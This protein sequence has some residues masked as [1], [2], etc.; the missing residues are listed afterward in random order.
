MP[1]DPPRHSTSPCETPRRR[2]G[3]TLAELIVALMLLTVGLLALASTSAF[4]TYEY[5]ASARAERAAIVAGTRLE[6]LRLAGC[7]SSQG[8]ETSEGLTAVWS[9]ILAGRTA[10]AAVGVAWNERGTPIVH[11]YATAFAC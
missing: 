10:I 4:L 1:I 2:E 11:R 3:F 8:T 7:V 6:T 5:A 9:V